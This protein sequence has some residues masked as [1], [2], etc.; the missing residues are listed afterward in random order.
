MVQGT[1]LLV[2][3]GRKR[4]WEMKKREVIGGIALARIHRLFELAEK[5]FSKHPERSNRYVELALRI[6]KKC[7]VSMPQELKKS[8]CKKCHCFLKEGVN[9]KIRVSG[10]ILKITCLECNSTKKI[11]AKR[12]KKPGKKE[13][14]RKRK[15]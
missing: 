12:G 11:S 3:K 14:A 6:S 5:E 2:L 13:P 4:Q 7:N 8:Y 10:S 9:S 15:Q 1:I